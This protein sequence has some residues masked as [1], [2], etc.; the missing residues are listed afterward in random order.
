MDRGQITVE[1][2]IIMALA[3]IIFLVT[4]NFISHGQ[5]PSAESLWA[6]DGQNNADLLAR[7]IDEVYIAGS[8]AV[9]NVTH[10]TSL[11]G[12]VGYN[13][14]VRGRLVTISVPVYGREFERKFATSGVKGAPSGLSLPAGALRISNAN[15]TIIIEAN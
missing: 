15:G 5:K 4:V 11:V 2:V 10:P 12:G 1:F 3:S 14:T 13:I 8:G 9:M 6:Q 7:E